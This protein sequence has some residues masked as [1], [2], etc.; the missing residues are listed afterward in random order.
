[1]TVVPHMLHALPIALALVTAPPLAPSAW[2]QSSDAGARS[3][4]DAA[5]DVSPEPGS[6]LPLTEDIRDTSLTAMRE[7]IYELSTLQHAAHQVHW[8]TIDIEFH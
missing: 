1:M 5:S 4:G 2:A 8:N 6:Y 3:A 7:T